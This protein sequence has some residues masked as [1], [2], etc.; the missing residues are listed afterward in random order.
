MRHDFHEIFILRF[1]RLQKMTKK[2]KQSSEN[3]TKREKTN[4]SNI[5]VSE[6]TFYTSRRHIKLTPTHIYL[7]HL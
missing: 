6:T 5:R 3:M 7:Q 2:Q 1:L 4:R